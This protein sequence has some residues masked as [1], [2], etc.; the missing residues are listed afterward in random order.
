MN[1]KF[2]VVYSVE[3]QSSDDEMYGNGRS[4]YYLQTSYSFNKKDDEAI[5]IRVSMAAS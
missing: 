4:H 2:G 1:F 5:S 3:G